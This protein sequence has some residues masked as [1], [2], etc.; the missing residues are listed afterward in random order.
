MNDPR[1]DKLADVLVN[2][3]VRVQKDQWVM[4]NTAIEAL[5]L[6]NAVVAKV[7]QAGGKPT[8]IMNSD[9][10]TET[11][12]REASA[13]QLAWVSPVESLLYEQTDAFIALRAASNTRALTGIDPEKQRIQQN[14]RRVLQ[15]TYMRRAAEGKLNWTLT[16]FPCAAYA[17]EADMSL[18]DYEN[19]VYA[20]TFADQADPVAA[21]Q[22][23]QADQARLVAWL[24]GKK[25]MTVKGEHI[26]MTLSIEGRSFINCCGE[27]NMPDGEI[28]TGPVEDSVNGWVRFSYPAIRGGREVEGVELHF[29]N[30]KV[31]TATASKNEAYLHAMLD[32]DPGARFLGEFAI[33]TNYRIQQFTKSILYDEKIGGTLH[34]AVGAGY[35]E[36]GSQNK[37]S[38]HWDFICDM[39]SS[40]ITVDGELFYQDGQF[41]V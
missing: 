23:V 32:S 15:E 25:Q 7:L 10:L 6:A 40:Q 16:Q 11:V 2:Y 29:E 1:I 30:G 22:Q 4:V 38:L 31:T 39:K 18:G 24:A 8:I 17:Q 34:M 26:D 9:A 27:R 41:V 35:P 13:E 5:P 36:T 33:G 20:A 37:S 3:S 28:F 12:L 21:W 14:A 19:F